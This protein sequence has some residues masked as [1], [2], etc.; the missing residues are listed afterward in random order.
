MS[1]CSLVIDVMLCAGMTAVRGELIN[2]SIIY[3]RYL[4]IMNGKVIGQLHNPADTD[5][6]HAA[7]YIA[8]GAGRYFQ[9]CAKL[10]H[11][12]LV[13]QADTAYIFTDALLKMDY[14]L[15]FCVSINSVKVFV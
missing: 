5:I 14:F 13:L 1:D 9:V 12:H 8:V 6:R 7:L 15:R 2:G 10:L 4:G 3:S 11:F